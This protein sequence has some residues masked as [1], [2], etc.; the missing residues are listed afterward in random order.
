[1]SVLGGPVY[2]R[3]APA[4]MTNSTGQGRG[5]FFAIGGGAGCGSRCEAGGGNVVL[6]DPTPFTERIRDAGGKIICQVQTLAQA[7]EAAA[8]G[9]DVI[10]AQGRHA[11]GHSG[12][13]RHDG[14]CARRG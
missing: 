1:M 8:A 13:T 9:A 11:G 4:E 12:M 6:C 5:D 2:D 3:E 7:K 14:A 10:V